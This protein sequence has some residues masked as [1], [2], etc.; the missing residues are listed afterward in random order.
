VLNS[1]DVSVAWARLFGVQASEKELAH[2]LRN[3]PDGVSEE[4]FVLLFGHRA[5]LEEEYKHMSMS[6]RALDEEGRGFL[7]LS[8]LQHAIN[9]SEVALP[10]CS[11]MDAADVFREADFDGDNR[12]SIRDFRRV[13]AEGGRH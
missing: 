6:F 1:F 12:V 2:L 7:T 9:A 4:D 8:A 10:K 3:H 13:W 11:Q 5:Q